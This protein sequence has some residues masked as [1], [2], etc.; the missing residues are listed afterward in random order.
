[1]RKYILLFI[2]VLISGLSYSQN[3]IVINDYKD[4][5]L[6]KKIEA[7]LKR[8]RAKSLIVEARTLEGASIKPQDKS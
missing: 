6:L 5:S 8:A 2:L 1:M 7:K 3:R 4:I